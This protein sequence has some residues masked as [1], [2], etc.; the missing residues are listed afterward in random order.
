MIPVPFDLEKVKAAAPI[1]LRNGS[2]ARVKFI[3]HVPEAHYSC[4][5]VFLIG[6]SI[7]LRSEEGRLGVSGGFCENEADILMVPVKKKGWINIYNNSVGCLCSTKEE[8]EIKATLNRIA[9]IKI[10]YTEGQGL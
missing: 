2:A 8:T 9:C 4:R 6:D 10:E 1:M 7:G 5:L 3:A